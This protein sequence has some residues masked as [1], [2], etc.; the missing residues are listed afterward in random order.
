M[1]KKRVL[2]FCNGVVSFNVER[3]KYTSNEYDH[4]VADKYCS[5]VFKSEGN[6]L[7]NIRDK[8]LPNKVN[9]FLLELIGLW[10]MIHHLCSKSFKNSDVVHLSFIEPFYLFILPFLKRK[11]LIVSVFGSDFYRFRFF[12]LIRYPIYKRANLITFS[13]KQTLKDFSEFYNKI[14]KEK[15]R[16]VRFGTDNFSEILKVSEDISIEEAKIK[17]G[18]PVDKV[19]VVVGI[20]GIPIAQHLLILES[21]SKLSNTLKKEI[22]VVIPASSVVGDSDNYLKKVRQSIDKSGVSGVVFQ[23]WLTSEQMAYFRKSS[24][25]LINLPSTDQFSASMLETLSCGNLV[26][27][28]SWLPYGELYDLG[29]KMK[30]IKTFNDLT[31]VLEVILAEDKLLLESYSSNVE[32][33]SPFINWDLIKFDWIELYKIV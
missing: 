20:N 18:F 11:K 28:G 24:E 32:L 26:V 21:I 6:Y 33:V 29:V 16:L 7:K 3:M 31:S 10:C 12:N 23:E 14:P 9:I 17:L 22:Y 30:V 5:K 27:T 1:K 4:Y 15:Y 25:I 8:R 13:S 2:N 19:V